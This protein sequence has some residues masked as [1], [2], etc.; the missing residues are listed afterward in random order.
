MTHPVS[1][2]RTPSSGTCP[3]P[4]IDAAICNLI[5]VEIALLPPDIALVSS[6][7]CVVSFLY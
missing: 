4:L 2:D 7:F 5:A 1:D 3:S 6:N